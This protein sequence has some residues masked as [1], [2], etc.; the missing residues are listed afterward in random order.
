MHT[1]SA[2]RIFRLIASNPPD[3]LKGTRRC[4]RWGEAEPIPF[5]GLIST[6]CRP[7][8]PK[9]DETTWRPSLRRIRRGRLAPRGAAKR[10]V[11]SPALASS[12]SWA[13]PIPTMLG[14]FALGWRARLD[15]VRTWRPASDHWAAIAR[16]PIADSLAAA[17]DAALHQTPWA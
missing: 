17:R 14:Q 1:E 6:K 8:D 15:S 3:V 16:T 2:R 12:S 5:R 7:V 10:Q 11:P 4:Y 9:G 13:R